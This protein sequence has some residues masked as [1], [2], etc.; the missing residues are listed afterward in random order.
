MDVDPARMLAELR[1]LGSLTSDELGAQRVAWTDTW[2]QARR[3]FEAK[4]AELPVEVHYDQ[5]GNLWATLRGESDTAVV[6]GSHL[7]SVP[8]G[9]WLD[10]PLGVLAGLEVIR[11]MASD[12]RPPITVRLVDWADEEGRFARSVLGSSAFAGTESIEVDRGK[13]DKDGIR[14]EDALRRCGIEIDRFPEARAERAGVAAYLELHIEQGPVL[15]SL[16]LPLGVV[17]GARGVQRHKVTFSGQEAHAGSTPMVGRKDALAAAAELALA[18][19]E[20][21]ARHGDGVCTIGSLKTF[22]GIATAIVGQCELTL[23]Q[24]HIDS[25]ALQSMLREARSESERAAAEHGCTVEWSRIWSIEPTFFDDE[26]IELCSQSVVEVAGRSHRLPSGPIH[27]AVEV[28]RSGI[29]T[30][31]MFV[32]SIAGMSHNRLEDTRV[33]HLEQAVRAFDRLATKTIEWIAIGPH[34]SR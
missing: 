2:L 3:W 14:L 30:V 1:E 28:S 5:A 32:Q 12:G 24:R 15:E 20:I 34:R 11:R 19:Y 10:G 25:A 21:A 16:D 9:G 26:L 31:M 27:D 6:L 13:T 23:D 18:I 22:P 17:T 7:D 8:N 4:L 33:E 29:P